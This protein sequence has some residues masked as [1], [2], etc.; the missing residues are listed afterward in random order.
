MLG[1]LVTS[2]LLTFYGLCRELLIEH[3]RRATICKVARTL[4]RGGSIL[5]VRPGGHMV[6]IHVPESRPTRLK[7]HNDQTAM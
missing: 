4:D 5:D 1:L 7:S 6:V 3:A 2:G